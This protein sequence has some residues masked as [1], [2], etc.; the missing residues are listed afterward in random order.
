MSALT[1]GTDDLFQAG[2][3]YQVIAPDSATVLTDPTATFGA[4]GVVAGDI[5][6]NT[7][8][9]SQGIVASRTG[10]QITLVSALTGGT[11]NLFQ[12]GDGYQVIAPDSATVLTDPTATF[13]AAG[14]VAGDIV[15][16]TTDG[17]QG[18]VASRTGTQI[19][20]V[21]ALTGGTDNLFQ[22]GDGY[23]VIAPD[24][25]TVLTDPTA[26]FGAAGVVAGDI[27]LNTTDGS[28]GIVASRTGT[29]ITLVSAL[30]GGTD[31]L[32]QAGDGYQVIAPDSATVLTDPT[33]TFG[34]AGVVA[35]DIVLNTTDGSQGIVASRTGKQITLVAALTGGTDF[36]P[37][38]FAAGDVYVVHAAAV[39]PSATV[40]NDATATSSPTAW[41]PAM[42][43]AT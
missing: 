31:N 36:N 17:S 10:T 12:A 27:V 26:T 30:T 24:S 4:A 37:N 8:D 14:V 16:N 21:S 20:L 19:T 35:G 42:S 43:S 3:G 40:L 22:A 38:I 23:Q 1:G 34:A 28:Q 39:I 11:D 9:G 18:I 2:D 13:G 6:L 33:A 29:Q 15:L 32:F 25:A 7:T 5:V 41:S